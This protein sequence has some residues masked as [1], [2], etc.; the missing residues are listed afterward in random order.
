[1]QLS[2][3]LNYIQEYTKPDITE[4]AIKRIHE[5]TV[6]RILAEDAV[7]AYRKSQVV[8]KNS[9]TGEI[10]FR[11]PPPVEVPF[12]VADFL[13]W[14][15]A[16]LPEDAHTVLKA[17]IVHYELVR[18]HPFLDGNGRVARATATLVLFL[19]GYDVK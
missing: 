2:Y 9:Q 18:I 6:H 14:V 19:G 1:T 8:V 7:A 5:L 17:G 13:H 15:N 10:T 12:L 4:D 11:P 16:T 3:V